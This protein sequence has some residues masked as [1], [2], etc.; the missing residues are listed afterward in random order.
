MLKRIENWL[1]RIVTDVV[2]EIIRKEQATRDDA[3]QILEEAL[4]GF[5]AEVARIHTE[6]LAA[7][8]KMHQEA[9]TVITDVHS[10][11]L[12]EKNRLAAD[13]QEKAADLQQALHQFTQ[14]TADDQTKQSDLIHQQPKR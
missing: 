2:S 10:D 11:I 5:R 6:E 13:L 4:S 3:R 8:S 12:A 1:R 7:F 14:W 9:V